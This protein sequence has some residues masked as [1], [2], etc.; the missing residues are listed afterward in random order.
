MTGS[1]I[2]ESGMIRYYVALLP[3]HELRISNTDVTEWIMKILMIKQTG[4]PWRSLDIYHQ[5]QAEHDHILTTSVLQ[6]RN[7]LSYVMF[8]L[9]DVKVS[10][11]EF[12]YLASI[13]SR[14]ITLVWV[15][16][17]CIRHYGSDAKISIVDTATSM[18]SPTVVQSW[19]RV[20][21]AVWMRDKWQFLLGV[22]GF[23]APSLLRHQEYKR[24]HWRRYCSIGCRYLGSL[25]LQVAR[26]GFYM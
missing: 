19:T 10:T 25:N 15:W 1:L 14:L 5:P 9:L 26:G 4:Q 12:N 7:V 6:A 3:L 17:I 22:V 11:T 23:T 13:L 20:P 8:K 18:A 2:G 16:T 21:L 24:T